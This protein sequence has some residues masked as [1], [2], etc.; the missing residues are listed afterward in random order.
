MT[1]KLS[2]REGGFVQ[3]NEFAIWKGKVAN[4]S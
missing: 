3:T 4:N 1:K 2:E